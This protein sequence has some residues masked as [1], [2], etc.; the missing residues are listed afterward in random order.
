MVNGTVVDGLNFSIVAFAICEA[1][2]IG[3]FTFKSY[4][5][6][7]ADGLYLLNDAPLNALGA[8]WCRKR[9]IIA[10]ISL[11]VD[12]LPKFSDQNFFRK[13]PILLVAVINS[14]E[15]RL[16]EGIVFVASVLPIEEN[17]KDSTIGLFISRSLVDV[18]KVYFGIIE[19]VID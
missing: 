16:D 13:L 4:Q 17:C 1:S 11:E 10:P 8:R 12:R 5:L 9:T 19:N 14:F 6:V 18:N 7:I 2:I 15:Y 3:Q